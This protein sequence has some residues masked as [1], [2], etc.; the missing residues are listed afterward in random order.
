MYIGKFHDQYGVKWEIDILLFSM[1][2]VL[3]RVLWVFMGNDL[4]GL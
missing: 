3:L 1:D 4:R 2:L